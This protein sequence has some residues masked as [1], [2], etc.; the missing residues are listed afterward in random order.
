MKNTKMK[1]I[2]ASV[3]V[4]VMSTVSLGSFYA[5]KSQVAPSAEDPIGYFTREE[6]LG[7]PYRWD[8]SRD[9]CLKACQEAVGWFLR[10]HPLTFSLSKI[11]SEYEGR[12]AKFLFKCVEETWEII[13]KDAKKKSH[14]QPRDVRYFWECAAGFRYSTALCEGF[15]K[16]FIINYGEKLTQAQCLMN[17][18]LFLAAVYLED[19]VNFTRVFDRLERGCFLY[20]PEDN[21]NKPQKV[22]KRFDFTYLELFDRLKE[23]LNKRLGYVLEHRDKGYYHAPI[24]RCHTVALRCIPLPFRPVVSP[25]FGFFW[26][27]SEN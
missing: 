22:F 21:P 4:A 8:G 10:V 11:S 16:S 17:I 1:K 25:L 27:P 12:Y 26:I 7:S 19:I 23:H 14:T 18:L 20:E 6:L 3:C 9:N 5:E 15:R 13:P 2:I 24:R